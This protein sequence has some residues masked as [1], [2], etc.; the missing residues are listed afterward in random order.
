M[1]EILDL[2]IDPS[3]V[4]E[5]FRPFAHLTVGE[6]DWD[7]LVDSNSSRTGTACDWDNELLTSG[8]KNLYL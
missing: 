3:L 2:L 1:S 4:K 5:I 8:L 6:R 7:E